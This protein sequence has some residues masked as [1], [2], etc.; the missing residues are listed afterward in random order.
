MQLFL[1][2]LCQE[3]KLWNFWWWWWWW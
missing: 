3:R 2:K 1:T